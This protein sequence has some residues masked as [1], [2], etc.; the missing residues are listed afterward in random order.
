MLLH[1]YHLQ[2]IIMK[3]FTLAVLAYFAMLGCEY[4]SA[5]GLNRDTSTLPILFFSDAQRYQAISPWYTLSYQQQQVELTTCPDQSCKQSFKF[6]NLNHA[7]SFNESHYQPSLKGRAGNLQQQD[8]YSQ[9]TLGHYNGNTLYVSG[10]Q[11]R[12]VFTLDVTNQPTHLQFQF[13]D[14]FDTKLSENQHSIERTPQTCRSKTCSTYWQAFN[15][16]KG[17][18]YIPARFATTEDGGWLIKNSPTAVKLE[19]STLIG[20]YKPPVK[21]YHHDNLTVT[22]RIIAQDSAI[23]LQKKDAYQK[24]NLIDTRVIEFAASHWLLNQG[25][26]LLLTNDHADIVATTS[27]LS[28]GLKHVINSA[29]GLE[30]SFILGLAAKDTEFRPLTQPIITQYPKKHNSKMVATRLIELD[31]NLNAHFA[32]TLYLPE[33]ELYDATIEKHPWGLLVGTGEATTTST[34]H[35]YQTNQSSSAMLGC[36]FIADGYGYGLLCWKALNNPTLTYTPSTASGMIPTTVVDNTTPT[37]MNEL[38]N[39]QH[40]IIFQDAGVPVDPGGSWTHPDNIATSKEYLGLAI[41]MYHTRWNSPVAANIIFPA[42]N[43]AQPVMFREVEYQAAN[44]SHLPH[45]M[46][47]N[48]AAS[49]G[50]PEYQAANACMTQSGFGLFTLKTLTF[51]RW[52]SNNYSPNQSVSGQD[53]SWFPWFTN[54]VGD[55]PVTDIFEG[56]TSIE[57][58]NRI[59]HNAAQYDYLVQDTYLQ[60]ALVSQSKVLGYYRTQP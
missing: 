41:A 59:K 17:G 25:D 20:E 57:M 36:P 1:T 53:N 50:Y 10:N 23:V 37:L 51:D 27:L 38:E 30:S 32:T 3:H 22:S 58:L 11:R 28:L 40:G 12:V 2:G 29:I 13:T 45:N 34:T 46:C 6:S 43:P 49:S 24:I 19:L 8:T 16:T 4:A 7:C 52:Q 48:F 33:S 31:R 47:N 9:L 26:T 35:T 42:G 55:P 14:G 56:Q 60:G 5:Q 21:R 15:V 18:H 54:F 44:S 39:N